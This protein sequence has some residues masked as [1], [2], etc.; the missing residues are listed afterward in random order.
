MHHIFCAVHWILGPGLQRLIIRPMWGATGCA[1]F[2]NN[3]D[4]IQ[5]Q[6]TAFH[7]AGVFVAVMQWFAYATLPVK[8]RSEP[9][10]KYM[11][12]LTVPYVLYGWV[13]SWALGVSPWHQCS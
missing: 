9:S 10:V 5:V 8:L 7:I 4:T 1:P 12:W 11:H 2:G 3:E 13:A 6:L